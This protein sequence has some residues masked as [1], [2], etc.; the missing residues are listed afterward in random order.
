MS[1]DA[2]R[3]AALLASC[4]ELVEWKEMRDQE[5]SVQ[6]QK[7]VGGVGRQKSRRLNEQC[8]DAEVRWRGEEG[9]RRATVEGKRSRVSSD[10]IR[11]QADGL[12]VGRS[13]SSNG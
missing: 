8:P 3:S 6:M 13:F 1:G 10:F 7:C 9:L 4:A 2:G 12:N 5:C 11:A